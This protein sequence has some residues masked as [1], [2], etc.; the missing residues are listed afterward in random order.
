MTKTS[1]LRHF[2]EHSLQREMKLWLG[3]NPVF[4]AEF[5]TDNMKR[6]L[7]DYYNEN[8]ETMTHEDVASLSLITMRIMMKSLKPPFTQ[9]C[10]KRVSKWQNVSELHI[11]SRGGKACLEVAKTAKN[12]VINWG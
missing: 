1:F 11:A 7:V 8:Q 3:K 5:I 9:S 12:I 10:V 4:S 2:S 6:E